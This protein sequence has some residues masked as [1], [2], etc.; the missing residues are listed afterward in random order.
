V[1]R[2]LTAIKRRE[3]ETE[4]FLVFSNILLKVQL[5]GIGTTTAHFSSQFCQTH[6]N[7]RQFRMRKKEKCAIEDNIDA[8]YVNYRF[9][10]TNVKFCVR[11]VYI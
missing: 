7:C 5:K 3:A 1:A 10:F 6:K 8:I 11:E 9:T 4:V 2:H